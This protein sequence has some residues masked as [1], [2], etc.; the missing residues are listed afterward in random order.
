MGV[1]VGLHGAEA[2]TSDLMCMCNDS[3]E[4][5]V[6]LQMKSIREK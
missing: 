4:I 2:G 5:L 6:N 3:A 1:I